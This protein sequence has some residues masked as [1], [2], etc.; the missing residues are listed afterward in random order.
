MLSIPIFAGA[1]IR[2]PLGILAQYVG[3]KNA[4]L[5][6]MAGISIAMLFG[7]FYVSSFN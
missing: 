6:E 5:V 4:T 7:H 2:F 1:L 3:R